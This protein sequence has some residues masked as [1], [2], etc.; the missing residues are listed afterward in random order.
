MNLDWERRVVKKQIKMEDGS[1]LRKDLSFIMLWRMVAKESFSK[2]ALS[3]WM[4]IWKVEI[5]TEVYGIE[6]LGL[7][8]V[9]N[10]Q[11]PIP[12]VRCSIGEIHTSLDRNKL[13]RRRWLRS[14]GHPI[15][16]IC[17]RTL[18]FGIGGSLMSV[19]DNESCWIWK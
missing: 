16:S 6:K 5:I 7:E 3:F 13:V 10:I 11:I 2:M 12:C 15:L 9:V 18:L 19:V 17:R 4:R 1:L 8:W 14:R